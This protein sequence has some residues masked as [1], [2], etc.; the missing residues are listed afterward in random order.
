MSTGALRGVMVGGAA[1]VAVGAAGVADA[2]VSVG[3]SERIIVDLRSIA[4][5]PE[6]G[7]LLTSGQ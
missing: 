6:D 5:R 7:S 3:I 2:A 4:P 1:W